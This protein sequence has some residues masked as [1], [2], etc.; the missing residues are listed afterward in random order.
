[1]RKGVKSSPYDNL[2]KS[3]NELKFYGIILVIF[4]G[5]FYV[6]YMS[7]KF[8]NHVITIKK[9]DMTKASMNGRISRNLIGDTT[10]NIYSVSSN[11]LLLFFKSAEI[12]NMLE[13]G[14]TFTVSGYGKRIP[15][16][17]V[18]PQ[19]THASPM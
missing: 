7:T 12:L 17:G 4:L 1:M 14:K 3:K 13:E 9:D 18:Y 2:S 11:P 8:S 6:Y 10:G 15:M 5:I 16:L 19:I